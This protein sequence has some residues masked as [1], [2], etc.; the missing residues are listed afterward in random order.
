M[1]LFAFHIS[2]VK[3]LFKRS[4][5]FSS[6]P[7]SSLTLCNPMNRS[8]PGLPVYHQLLEVAQTH[9]HRVGNTIQPLSS[10]VVSFSSCLQSF[11]MNP[12]GSF[13]MNQF[14]ALGGPS[15]G[16]SASASVLPKNTQDW[17]PLGW[18]GLISMQ[19]KGLST[20][21]SSTTIWKHQF[22]GAQPCV[23]SSCHICTW[24]LEKP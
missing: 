4:A 13:P 6:V 16:A 12:S 2:L 10:S 21:F 1:W 7:R 19:S 20:V 9:V 18:T 24:L 14:F 15:I 11:P 22:F 8:M 5:Q 3:C 17:F 23:W